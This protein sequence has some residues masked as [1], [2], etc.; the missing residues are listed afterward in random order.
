MTMPRSISAPRRLAI[1]LLALVVAAA[2]FAAP[3]AR[4]GGLADEAEL[5]FQIG[6]ESYQKGDFR[7]AL[8]HFFISNR[9]VP[10]RNVVFNIAR[11]YEQMKRWADAHRYFTDALEEEDR[12]QQIQNIQ[13]GLARVTPYVAL[14]K[15]ES[16]PPGATIYIDRKDLGSRGKAPRAL[17]LAEGKYRVIAELDGHEPATSAPIE[18]KAG[19]QIVVPLKLT[20][21][22]GTIEVAVE[23]EGGAT[24]HLDD[25]HAPAICKAPCSFEAP[26]GRHL[27]YFT[28]EGF[29]AVPR[30]VNV[31]ARQTVKT[32]VSLAPLTGSLVVSADERDAVV[33]IDGK[34]MG[35][36]PAVIQNVAVGKRHVRVALRGY[37]PVERDIEVKTGQQA[38][39]LNLELTPLRQ[40]SAVS[41]Y[42]ES[43]EDAPSSVTVID[44]QELRAFGYPTI[45]EALRGTRGIYISND[46]A[47]YSA[48]VRGL[49]EPNDYGNRLLVLSDGASLNDNILSSSYIGSDARPDLHDV[50]RIEIVRG[51]GSLLYGTGAFS[52]VVNLVPRAKDEPSSVHVGAGT[53]DNAVARGRAG[54]HYNFTPKV[55]IWA[56]VSGA[57]SDGVDV[58]IPLIDPGRGTV[59]QTANNVDHFRSGSTAGRFWAGPL[60]VQWFFTSRDQQI[61]VGVFQ[62]QFNDHRTSWLDRRYLLEVRFEPKVSENV[63]IFT[64]AHANRYVFGGSYAN[65][66][67]ADDLSTENYYG[68]WFGGEAR[69]VF[70]PIKQLRFTIGGEGQAHVQASIEGSYP[71]ESPYIDLKKQYGFGAG[72][73]L[74][75]ASPTTW[76]H[77]S[78]G[79]RMDVYTTFGA[80]PVPR[81]AIIFKPTKGG[82]L[83]IMGGR[84]FRAPS[85]YEQFYTDGVTQAPGNQPNRKLAL[86]PE[87]IYQGEIEYSQRFLENWVALA[88]GHVG[89]VQNIITSVPDKAGS[90][91]IRYANSPDPALTAGGDV[92]IRREWRQ[93]WMVSAMYGYQHARFLD[94]TKTPLVNAPQHLASMRGVVPLLPD[95]ASLATRITLEAPRRISADSTETTP[96]AVVAD[97]T[98][99]GNIKRFGVQYVLGVYN[100]ADSRYS[101]PVA[102]TYLS[103][104]MPQNGRTFLADIKVTYP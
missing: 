88:A 33:E 63:Q 45:A 54:F 19:S 21:I 85:I 43:I 94:A 64:R 60:T 97:V 22:V 38:E 58:A 92:E 48:G 11:T 102:D 34:P 20:R 74:G 81:G 59:T 52:G 25:E 53:Y 47:Y 79:F 101:Y 12:P 6:A 8:E 77:L 95:I 39:L 40:V 32:T 69:V 71:N 67:S 93:G 62:S 91:T 103:R 57:R 56:S 36:T 98:L 68:T 23:G 87:T 41:R 100:V 96:T 17:A 18:I 3:E 7:G 14:L 46:R 89:Y 16:D 15:V 51:P 24:V 37:A 78:A 9:L 83:K 90:D 29:Q 4:A 30:Q 44:G 86:G 49:G 61:P 13:A 55:G 80:V 84:A 75:E 66:K 27:I 65:G 26:P 31:V 35:F 50:D 28:R 42:E 99:S 5:H 76:L 2:P 104:T 70:S 82:A 73:I 72:Y 10:N 1:S